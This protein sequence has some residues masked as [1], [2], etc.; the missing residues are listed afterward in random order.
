MYMTGHSHRRMRC[1]SYRHFIR[2]RMRARC[3]VELPLEQLMPS[4]LLLC[5][6]C[7]RKHLLH[8]PGTVLETNKRTK[9]ENKN[10]S[11]IFLRTVLCM[12]PHARLPY[13]ININMCECVRCACVGMTD[14]RMCIGWIERVDFTSTAVTFNYYLPSNGWYVWSLLLLVWSTRRINSTIEN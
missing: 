10:D 7:V 3:V 13:S 2:N 14:E 4:Y 11:R 6:V 5:I 8:S 1:Y 9:I 12:C